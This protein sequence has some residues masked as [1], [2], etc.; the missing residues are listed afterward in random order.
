MLVYYQHFVENEH[1]AVLFFM[2]F[3]E[4]QHVFHTNFAKNEANISPQ[5]HGFLNKRIIL[6]PFKAIFGLV[7]VQMSGFPIMW[8][9]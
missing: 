8:I 1:W 2:S 6:S 4:R 3:I 7:E 5:I 9:G